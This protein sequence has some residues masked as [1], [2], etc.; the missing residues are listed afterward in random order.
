[1][2]FIAYALLIIGGPIICA[3]W[4]G[5][6]SWLRLSNRTFV[7]IIAAGLGALSCFALLYCVGSVAAIYLGCSLHA[8]NPEC[9]YI[10]HDTL[11]GGPESIRAPG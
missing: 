4:V 7:A 1:M 9:E 2:E 5:R 10:G 8:D 11:F 6:R 3:L